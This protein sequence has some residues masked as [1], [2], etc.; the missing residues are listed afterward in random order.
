LLIFCIKSSVSATFYLRQ[1]VSAPVRWLEEYARPGPRC[2]ESIAGLMAL[3]DY[4][5][6]QAIRACLRASPPANIRQQAGSYKDKVRAALSMW[7]WPAS[8]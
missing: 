8:D 1:H 6:V 5:N 3:A 7:N 4:A 2:R